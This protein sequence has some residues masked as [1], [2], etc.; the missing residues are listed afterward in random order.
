MALQVV[1]SQIN[2]HHILH[3]SGQIDL[4]N[5]VEFTKLL[6]D[7]IDQ[8]GESLILNLKE[9]LYIDSS[10]LGALLTGRNR[11][12]EKN[13]KLGLLNIKDEIFDVMKLAT[14]DQ[15]FEIYKTESDIP[16][17]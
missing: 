9:L 7:E 2:N 11:M 12:K 3:L 16:E 1:K 15:F 14:I 8:A 4:S 5:I 10:G 6:L 13:G 17:T